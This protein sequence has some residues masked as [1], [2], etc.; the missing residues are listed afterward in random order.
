MCN[1]EGQGEFLPGKVL[2]V[3]DDNTFDVMYDNGEGEM[4]V[5]AE[6]LMAGMNMQQESS[7]SED[8]PKSAKKKSSIG[9]NASAFGS[10]ELPEQQ[11]ETSQTP[12]APVNVESTPPST[13]AWQPKAGEKCESRDFQTKEWKTCKITAV[14]AE[15]GTVDL[16]YEG[17]DEGKG[18]PLGLVRERR[19]KSKKSRAVVASA[20]PALSST[21]PL[22]TEASSATQLKI[23]QCTLLLNAMAANEVDAALKMLQALKSVCSS[24]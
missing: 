23:D 1:K 19:R 15:L 20:Q 7:P 6:F 3:H 4:K 10:D 5:K 11:P 8:E 17:G 24:K 2:G 18:I 9:W 21:Q 13:A 14:D 22:P 12:T 16:K